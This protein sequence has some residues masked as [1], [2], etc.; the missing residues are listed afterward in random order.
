MLSDVAESSGDTELQK[1]AYR[2]QGVFGDGDI[3]DDEIRYG[4]DEHEK[5]RQKKLNSKYGIK[6][7]FGTQGQTHTLGKINQNNNNQGN[8]T[9]HE[10]KREILHTTATSCRL[11]FWTPITALPIN[12]AQSNSFLYV[13]SCMAA[14]FVCIFY[15]FNFL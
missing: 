3:D 10:E 15:L 6:N 11:T 8:Y 5:Y 12:V 13:V 1:I 7:T 14:D 2:F 9:K 4:D